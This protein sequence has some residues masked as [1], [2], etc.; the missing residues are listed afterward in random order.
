MF[1]PLAA[2]GDGE[3]DEWV[4]VLRRAIGGEVEESDGP[5]TSCQS[6]LWGCGLGVAWGCGLGG[7]LPS[8][9]EWVPMENHG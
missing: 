9:W 3:M 2:D 5:G 8:I 7:G 6:V 1:Y 4:S